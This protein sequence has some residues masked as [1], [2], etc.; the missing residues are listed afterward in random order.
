[1]SDIVIITNRNYF[2]CLIKSRNI[3]GWLLYCYLNDV[4]MSCKKAEQ[5]C[6]NQLFMSHTSQRLDFLYISCGD[7]VLM[8]KEATEISDIKLFKCNTACATTA[9]L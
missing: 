5:R 9:Q 1:M 3:N 7:E 8:S 2:E 4:Y 6:S